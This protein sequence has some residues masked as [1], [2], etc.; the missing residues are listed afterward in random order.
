MS[1]ERHYGHVAVVKIIDDLQ[2]NTNIE[3]RQEAKDLE[4]AANLI[5]LAREGAID[6]EAVAKAIDNIAS[7]KK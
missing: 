3:D 7:V 1:L 2:K 4:Q 5:K 6:A